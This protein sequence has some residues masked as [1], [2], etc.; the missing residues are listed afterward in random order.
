MWSKQRRRLVGAILVVFYMLASLTMVVPAALADGQIGEPVPVK[1]CDPTE[2]NSQ[3]GSFW[4]EI[5]FTL[6]L[7][8]QTI[9]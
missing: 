6:M 5:L 7:L 4:D 9:L 8:D 1:A 2:P 3:A